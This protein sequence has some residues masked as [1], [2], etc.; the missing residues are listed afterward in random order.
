M[1]LLLT[2]SGI[3]DRQITAHH[4][5]K[6]FG[7]IT[8]SI[9]ESWLL[10]VKTCT[11]AYDRSESFLSK[12]AIEN[13]QICHVLVGQSFLARITSNS[14]LPHSIEIKPELEILCKQRKSETGRHIHRQTYEPYMKN[15]IGHNKLSEIQTSGVC[16][17][18]VIRTIYVQQLCSK[19]IFFTIESFRGTTG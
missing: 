19:T 6:T 3:Y 7:N 9:R 18:Q 13:F 2:I 10:I 8:R 15:I 17:I 16:Y 12:A 5:Q 14:R 4:M 1:K 11:S